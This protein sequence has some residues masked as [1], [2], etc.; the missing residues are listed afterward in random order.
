MVAD[1]CKL[2]FRRR[3]YQDAEVINW[4]AVR[5]G[6]V[7]RIGHDIKMNE[8]T[9]Q[10]QVLDAPIEA[11]D[12]KEISL[13]DW[14]IVF[15]QRKKLL[16]ALPIVGAFCAVVLSLLLPNAYKS[17]TKIL[18][19][20]QAQSGAAALLSQLGGVASA[21]AG[22]AGIKNPNDLYVGMLKSRTI[23]DELI[24]EFD[25]LTVYD[26]KLWDQARK[27]LESNTVISSG[28][29]GLINIEVEDGDPKRAMKIANAY[30]NSLLKLTKVIAVTEA[31]QRRI[32]FE[33]QLQTAKD[34]LFES[35]M[36][37][38]AS[39][40]KNGVISVDAQSRAIVETVARVRAQMAAKEIQ[41][42]ASRAFMTAE[43]PEIKRG[44]QEL[45]SMKS[46]MQR[47]E[48]GNTS[49]G[50]VLTSQTGLANMKLLRDVKYY[51]ML[52]ELLSKQY[53]VA[54]LDESKDSSIVQVLDPAIE[55]ERKFKPKRSVLGIFGAVLGLLAAIGWVI[56]SENV[57]GNKDLE[58]Q[59]KMSLLRANIGFRIRQAV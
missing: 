23:A 45:I 6:H 37:L 33:R 7:R 12:E 40:D 49:S 39:L 46:E 58:F 52:Y 53:E 20:Q 2:G 29:D 41:L 17:N 36:S 48:N 1:S 30:S 10:G 11:D 59:R 32:F 22:A 57:R 16:F 5:C 50:G 43:H 35:E 21:A 44:E 28:K 9:F 56:M 51:Q 55:A 42:S 25:L 14:L 15:S 4:M 3:C 27:R 26:V 8:K 18:P 19:P 34:K 31:G 24:K 54:R 13:L 47:L 38:K